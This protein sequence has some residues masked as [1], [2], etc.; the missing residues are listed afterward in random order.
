MKNRIVSIIV[1]YFLSLLVSSNSWS[2]QKGIIKNRLYVVNST[3]DTAHF[4]IKISG[5]LN[6]VRVNDKLMTPTTDSTKKNNKITVTGE[7]NSVSVIQTNNKSEVI[8]TQ[9]GGNN[10]VIISQNK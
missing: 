3:I 8:I 7:G 9:K 5:S 4:S 1:L 6:C 2:Q 10:K